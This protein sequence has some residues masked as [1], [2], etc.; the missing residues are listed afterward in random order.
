MYRIVGKSLDGVEI[1]SNTVY[2]SQQA[3]AAKELW[4]L[5]HR[6]LLHQQGGSG[7]EQ[8]LV[9]DVLPV[10]ALAIESIFGG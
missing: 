10:A 3:Q 7:L 6:Q 2:D 9:F 4:A 1:I 8:V 5:E